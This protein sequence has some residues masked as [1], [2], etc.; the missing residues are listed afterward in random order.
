MNVTHKLTLSDNSPTVCE[1]REVLLSH[2]VPDG[3]RISYA[4][5]DWCKMLTI[6]WDE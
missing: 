1:F 6:E 4:D 5:D 3:A 2:R